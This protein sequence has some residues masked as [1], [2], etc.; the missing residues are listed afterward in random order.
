MPI[1]YRLIGYGGNAL[2]IVLGLFLVLGDH[3]VP[4]LLLGA[5]GGMNIY[6]VRILD[7]WTDEEAVLQRELRKRQLVAEIRA[8]DERARHSV[9]DHH[10]GEAP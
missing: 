8:H 9:S 1:T 10:D 4:G 5:L 2:L 6:L 7:K 3:V